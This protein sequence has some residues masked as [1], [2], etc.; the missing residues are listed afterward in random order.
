M[1]CSSAISAGTTLSARYGRG[2][3]GTEGTGASGVAA[4]S[5]SADAALFVV[6][7]VGPVATGQ[8]R[9]AG[10]AGL[11]LGHGDLF[12]VPATGLWRGRA[13]DAGSARTTVGAAGYQAIAD[14][15]DPTW[16]PHIAATL[17]RELKINRCHA[18][19]FS[20]LAG[21]VV[22]R[23]LQSLDRK[24]W[25]GNEHQQS[26]LEIAQRAWTRDALP[27]YVWNRKVRPTGIPSDGRA[28]EGIR[29]SRQQGR[30]CTPGAR[31]RG[32]RI[33]DLVEGVFDTPA[34][35]PSAGEDD[36]ANMPSARACLEGWFYSS[37]SKTKDYHKG[38]GA[39]QANH[40][41]T[42]RTA[43]STFVSEVSGTVG[44]AVSGEIKVTAKQVVAEE[45]AKFGITHGVYRLKAYGYSQYTYS[46]CYKGT[47]KKA[48]VYTPR[49]VGWAIWES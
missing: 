4:L 39:E 26:L 27:K 24:Y 9:T 33:G 30:G 14:L 15:I 22:S 2:A 25:K 16:R 49:R 13:P 1:R 23:P 40:N 11:P 21:A 20:E 46:N 42:S 37:T 12:P 38:V 5:G 35:A 10:L 45:E 28:A 3:A 48:T 43:K 17:R 19:Q 34:P 44:V 8:P 18:K 6:G 32:K 29:G 7:T 47:K 36:G 41:G 31:Q